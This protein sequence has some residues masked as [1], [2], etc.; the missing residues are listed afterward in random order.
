MALAAPSE[1]FI[2]RFGPLAPAPRM[3]GEFLKG[4]SQEFRTGISPVHEILVFPALL[5]NGGDTG[6]LL[7]VRRGL[8]PIPIRAERRCQTRS[9]CC[10]RPGEAFKDE[11]IGML[12]KNR[13]DFAIKLPQCCATRAA[14]GKPRPAPSGHSIPVPPHP[15]S[16]RGACWISCNCSLRSNEARGCFS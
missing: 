10:T 4:L 8:K 15:A 16:A 5:G 7:H 2:M 14:T 12:A 11:A 9:Q 3:I 1:K 6:H 13:G